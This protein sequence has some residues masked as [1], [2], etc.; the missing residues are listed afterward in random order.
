MSW[1]AVGLTVAGAV[2]GKMKNDRAKAVENSSRQ[3]ASQTQRYSPWTGLQAQPIQNAGSATGDVLG[4]GLAGLGTAQSMG[5]FGKKQ[6]KP[7]GSW[8]DALKKKPEEDPRA[9]V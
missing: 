6:E 5:A 2:A 3:L 1:I 9:V 8:W 4:G 7:E